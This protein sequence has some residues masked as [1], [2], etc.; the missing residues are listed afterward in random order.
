MNPLQ[1]ADRAGDPWRALRFAWRLPWLL[2]HLLVGLPFTVLAIKLT[3]RLRT[4]S[5]ERCDHRVI[6]WWSGTLLRIF[7]M[8]VRRFGTPMAQAGFYVANHLSWIDIAL[9]PSQ[10]VAGFVAKAEISRWP[11]VGWLASLAGTIYHHRGNNESLHGVMH[12]MLQRLQAGDSVAVFPEGRTTDG[13]AI[14]TFHARIFQPA[15]LA[16]AW[17]QPVALRYGEGGVAQSVVAFA[18]GEN[19]LQNFLRLL[20]EPSRVAEVHFLIP[21]KPGEEGRRRL[22]DACREQI[23]AA[24][25]QSSAPGA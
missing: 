19:F 24:M 15:V 12:Q 8:R 13:R 10:K 14:A 2:L 17:V 4:P 23:A 1:E 5:G 18:D 3:A 7:G 11:L 6:R 22:A 20:G 9:M 25:R 21:Q 16:E